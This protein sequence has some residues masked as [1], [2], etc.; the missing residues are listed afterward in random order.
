MPRLLHNT[1]RTDDKGYT[2]SIFKIRALGPHALFTQMKAMIGQQHYNG[3]VRQPKTVKRIQQF[4]DLRIGIT[5]RGIIAL[6]KLFY[7][8]V[9]NGAFVGDI[10]ITPQLL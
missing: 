2:G 1:R 10:G 4:A 3:I 5:Y 8:I 7:F 6:Y 9:G